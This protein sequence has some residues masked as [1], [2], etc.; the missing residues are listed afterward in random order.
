MGQVKSLAS[1][2]VR[3]DL[4][5][6]FITDFPLEGQSKETPK[7]GFDRSVQPAIENQSATVSPKA[8]DNLM[9]VLASIFKLTDSPQKLARLKSCRKAN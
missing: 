1:S 2:F 4:H 3:F 6:F 5:R 8:D 9:K 7:K